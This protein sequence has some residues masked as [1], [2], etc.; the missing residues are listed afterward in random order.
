MYR[1]QYGVVECSNERQRRGT[2]RYVVDVVSKIMEE[3]GNVEAIK[4]L[5][6]I[7]K[8]YYRDPQGVMQ[9]M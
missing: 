3:E 4:R 8:W 1:F 5:E 9:G 6:S 2:R 7:N